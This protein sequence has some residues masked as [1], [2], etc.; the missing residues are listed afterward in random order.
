MRHCLLGEAHGDLLWVILTVT[1]K[2]MWL[3][4]ILKIRA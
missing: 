3:Q 1:A 4:T 2:A